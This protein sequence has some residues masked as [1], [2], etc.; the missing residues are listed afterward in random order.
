MRKPYF[1]VVKNA[2]SPL[3]LSITRRVRFE[4]VDLMGIV[5]HG[6]YPSYFEDGRVTLGHKYGISYSDFIREKIIVPIRQMSIDYHYPLKFEDDFEIKTILHWSD[7]SRINIEYEIRNTT[8][9]IVCTGCSVQLILDQQ[10]NVLLSPPPFFENFL[11]R[12]KQGDF[13]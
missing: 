9:K 1:P 11:K 13:A 4:E 6:C 10:Y 8:D 7:A 2:P 12:W 3:S 5:W